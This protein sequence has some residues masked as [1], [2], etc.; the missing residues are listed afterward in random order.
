MKKIGLII[1]N[2]GTPDT[3]HPD[4]VGRYLKEFLMDKEIISI[5]FF[6]RYFLV[7][8][9]IV[10]RR[11][12]ASAL[13]YKK[14]WGQS[15]SPLFEITESFAQK[16]KEV[17]PSNYHVELGMR[18]GNPSIQQALE[19]LKNKQVDQIIFAPMYPQYAKATTYSAIEKLK[20]D[21]IRIF[22]SDQNLITVNPFYEKSVFIE[23][24]AIK[25][26][27]ELSSGKWQH[28]LFSFHGLPESQVKKNPGCLAT[29]NCC[30]RVEACQI[31]CYRAQCFA[32]AK[33]IAAN[34]GLSDD[35]Y[36]VC[37]QSRLGPAKWIQPASSDVVVELA[38]R[39][40]KSVLVQTPSF[41]ADCLETL[42]EIAI[43]LKAEFVSQGGEDL[44]LVACL[45]DDEEWVRSFVEIIKDVK[46]KN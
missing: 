29:K 41:V 7:H 25:L 9:I 39:G 27:K 34:A 46:I 17:L 19:N 31:N 30:E 18:Y 10:P 21:M 4:D 8:F 28:V 43:E 35:Q 12:F 32:S 22:G 6:V 40:I 14:V 24:S 33:L 15:K 3:Y 16:L 23:N 36:T 38:N 44:K 13:K 11:R 2:I 20:M 5:P 1:N 26:K 45:N 42:E 37:F